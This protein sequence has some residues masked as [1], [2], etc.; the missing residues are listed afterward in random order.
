M[1]AGS[2]TPRDAVG[3]DPLEARELSEEHPGVV[4]ERKR[5]LDVRRAAARPLAA[6]LVEGYE[7]VLQ[8]LGY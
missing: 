5:V 2:L 4:Q 7:S 8:V 1:G 6:G 3:K